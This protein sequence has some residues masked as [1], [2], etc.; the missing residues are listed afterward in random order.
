MDGDRKKQINENRFGGYTPED[1]GE[2]SL[3]SILAEYKSSAYILGEK[4]MSRD[5]LEKQADRILKEMTKSVSSKTEDEPHLPM[6]DPENAKTD[7]ARSIDEV[8]TQNKKAGLPKRLA[9]LDRKTER[10]R[11]EPKVKKQY[12]YANADGRDEAGVRIYR[13]SETISRTKPR[14]GE[15]IKAEKKEETEKFKKGD[16]KAE[17][18]YEKKKA[19]LKKQQLQKQIIQERIKKQEQLEASYLSM[20]ET[21]QEFFGVGKYARSGAA[22]EYAEEVDEVIEKEAERRHKREERRI[23]RQPKHAAAQ[24]EQVQHEVQEISLEDA[25]KLYGSGIVSL[26]RRTWL[27]GFFCLIMVYFLFAE[28]MKLALPRLFAENHSAFVLFFVLTQLIVLFLGVDV[29]VTGLFDMLKGRI[30]AESLV[31][32]ASLAAIIDSIT[33]IISDSRAMGLPFCTV[34]SF[35]VLCAMWG[36]RLGKTAFRRTF[37]VMSSTKVPIV[38]SAEWEKADVG[39]V[40]TKRLGSSKGFISKCTESDF[41]ERAY[42]KMAPLLI[43]AS[44]V[45]AFLSSV[46]KAQGHSFMHCFSAM[47]AVSASFSALLAF[48]MPFQSISRNLSGFGAAIA[49]W[50]GA[51][52]IRD[53][54]AMVVKDSDLF[55]ENT[56]SLNGV[57]VFSTHSVEK[58]I[59][60]TGSMVLATGSGL[61]RVFS[62]LLKEYACAI[63]RVDQFS[64]YEGGGIGA[65]IRGDNVLIGSAAFMNLMG[66]RLSP[67][68][69]IRSAVF[70]AINNELAGVFIINYTPSAP[71]QFAL[72]NLIRSKITP[73]FAVRDFNITPSMVINKFL[74]PKEDLEF[75]TF[76][77]RYSLSA[78][79]ENQAIKPAAIMSR[80]GLGHFV[81]LVRGGRQI[82]SLTTVSVA[83]S[84]LGSVLGLLIMFF[85]C[86]NSAFRS[87]SPAN[88]LT[89]M[90]CWL[91]P[92]LLLTG[93]GS[94]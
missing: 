59:S 1:T 26:K 7:E 24:T 86:W 54:I 3:E 71:V 37:K 33:M 61:T 32:I 39:I 47:T 40:L 36:T 23:A 76:E 9:K 62:D 41:G 6:T 46:V 78:N 63:Y 90:L 8:L 34:T 50:S 65:I 79:S 64:C 17:K 89:F 43:I 85:L 84:I 28:D 49:G 52:D 22:K 10:N 68:L 55:P 75:P 42:T 48:N 19:S 31:S 11:P 4:K 82:K 94:R 73:L 51:C 83:I 88:T 12:T 70:T 2:Y 56:L 80:E 69:N 18:E 57:K 27:A 60:Y 14:T 45:F 93:A 92:V 21:E 13:A 66:V 72:L 30:G 25:V 35:S 67:N 81:E 5:E 74:I 38:V 53:A 44:L 87:G 58:V 29:F 91:L 20:D 77:A 16:Y 15:V